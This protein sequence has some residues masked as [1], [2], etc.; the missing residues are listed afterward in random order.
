MVN[1]ERIDGAFFYETENGR[2]PSFKNFGIVGANS[3]QF[4]DV[5]E[6][7][8]IDFLG[9]S[10]PIGKTVSLRRQQR[11]KSVEGPPHAFEAIE[12]PKG[13]VK[14]F[15]ELARLTIELPELIFELSDF[16]RA[17]VRSSRVVFGVRCKSAGNLAGTVESFANSIGGFGRLL[18]VLGAGG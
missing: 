5:E 18:H 6:A 13:V 1:T 16:R 3:N 2:M 8:V 11:I 7:P 9:C 4:V 15:L 17:R 10:P 14:R 12:K